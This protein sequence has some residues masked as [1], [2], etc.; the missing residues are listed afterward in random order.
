MKKDQVLK[1][2]AERR[3]L[4][5]VLQLQHL[6]HS[7]QHEHI[8]R[9]LLSGCNQAPHTSAQQLHLL[10]QLAKLLGVKRDNRLE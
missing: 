10:D 9:D 8:R 5:T 3:R 6:L 7:L 2:E 1:A 4:S